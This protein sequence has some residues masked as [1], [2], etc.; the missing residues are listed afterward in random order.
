MGNLFLLHAPFG[1]NYPQIASREV[2]GCFLETEGFFGR[3]G[4]SCGGLV[5]ESKLGLS[6]PKRDS[7]YLA[8][9]L[10][11]TCSCKGCYCDA[12]WCGRGYHQLSFES[13]H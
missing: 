11:K 6:L 1:K 12:Q 3:W 10:A 4:L 9:Y 5:G 8:S 7:S 13:G 2:F